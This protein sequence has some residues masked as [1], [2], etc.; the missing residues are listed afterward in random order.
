MGYVDRTIL[1]TT[2]V[3]VREMFLEPGREVSW[4]F[5]TEVTDTMY[6]LRGQMKVELKAPSEERLLRPGDGCEIVAGRPHRITVTGAEP[7]RYLLIQGV[8]R[9][10]FQS[11]QGRTLSPGEGN[12]I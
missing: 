9:Y 3:R 8:G 7:V 4:H 6:C 1:Q 5:H 2:E 10:D 11:V 12:E